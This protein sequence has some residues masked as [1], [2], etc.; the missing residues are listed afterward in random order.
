[1]EHVYGDES[2]TYKY[3]F[4]KIYGSGRGISFLACMEINMETIY[5]KFGSLYY[6]LSQINNLEDQ[7]SEK[8]FYISFKPNHAS[9]Q[10]YR[11]VTYEVSAL[12][13]APQFLRYFLAFDKRL[14]ITK[15]RAEQQLPR[16]RQHAIILWKVALR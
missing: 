3:V 5:T 14:W 12:R 13:L 6:G 10:S 8:S 16:E 4:R 11:A 9:D 2:L 15:T 1:M 7:I